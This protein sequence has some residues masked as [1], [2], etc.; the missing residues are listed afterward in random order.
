MTALVVGHIRKD[1]IHHP[2]ES[3][4]I[5]HHRLLFHLLIQQ[6]VLLSDSRSMEIQVDTPHLIDKFQQSL[7][8]IIRHHVNLHHL[9]PAGEGFCQFVQRLHSSCGHTYMPPFFQ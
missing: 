1:G 4:G 9:H 8:R 6:H 7:G 2:R 3:Q 5:G